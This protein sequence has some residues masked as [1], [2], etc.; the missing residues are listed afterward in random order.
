M[1]NKVLALFI[2]AA[3]LVSIQCYGQEKQGLVGILY[4]DLNLTRITSLWYLNSVNSSETEWSTKND[5]SAKWIGYLEAP[6]TGEITFYGE[7]DNEMQIFI[8]GETVVN[9]WDKLKKSE[10]KIHLEKGKQYGIVLKYR[11]IEGTSYMRALWSWEGHEKQIIAS[12]ALKYESNNEVDI[13]KEFTSQ[14][15]VDLSKLKFD[16]ASIIDIHSAEDVAEKRK[17][18]VDY[19]W[20]GAGFP[21]E[22]LPNTITKDIVDT[23]FVSLKNLKQIDKITVDMEYDLNSI[24]YHFVPEKSNGSAAIYHQGHGGKFVLGKRTINAFLEKGYAVFALS[25]PLKGMNTKPV[26]AFE[27]TGNMIIH[28]HNLMEYLEPKTGHPIKYFMEPVGAIV[29]YSQQFNFENFF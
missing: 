13:Q 19:L 8:E 25:M 10:G 7:A 26:I 1:K 4:N 16:V 17:A 18:V 11:Q 21:F 5:F 20:G 9:T 24:I 29:N 2:V 23:N 28:S 22:K 6:I 14:V 27:R 3:S 15:N 12:E